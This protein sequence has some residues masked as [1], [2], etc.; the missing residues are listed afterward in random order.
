MEK[1]EGKKS[2][3]RKSM[4]K[5]VLLPVLLL[6]FLVTLA[7]VIDIPLV[8]SWS[9]LVDFTADTPVV[10]I[11]D[12]PVSVHYVDA[13][14]SDCIL[15][16]AYGKTV[17]IDTG[18]PSV[19]RPVMAYLKRQ[20]VEQ[21]D[22]L[23]LTHPHEDHMGNMTEVLETYP[24]STVIMTYLPVALTP[25]GAEYQNL[26]SALQSKNITVKAAIA[27]ETL[28]LGNAKLRILGPSF[29][30][31]NLND[32]S[33]ACKLICSPQ[34][35][36]LFMGDTEK[37]GENALLESK[38]DLHATV[39]KVGHHGSN[40]STTKNFL[41]A[42]QPRYAVISCGANNNYGFPSSYVLSRL[43]EKQAQVFRTDLNGSVIFKMVSENQL[44]VITER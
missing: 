23:I 33:I 32:S 29:V 19:R 12:A 8:P 36:F 7:E 43:E 41:E 44:E 21:I 2:F 40:T 1:S 13:D 18:D 9:E 20:K 24:V 15:I 10:T 25:T 37:E 14:Q 16:F 17:L 6:F 30:Y 39:L 34:L 22:Y 26:I 5:I 11:H 35:S 4:T 38:T 28:S 3:I 31:D 27:G 42:V